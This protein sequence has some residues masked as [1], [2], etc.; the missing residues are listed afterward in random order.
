M[1]FDNMKKFM[2]RLTSW[3][4]PGN[5][6]SVCIDNKEVFKYQS[7][8]EDIENRVKMSSDK[9]FNV[10]SCSKLITVVAA[11]QLYEKGY[12]LLDDPL[13]EYIPEYKTMYIKDEKGNEKKACNNITL[14]HLFTMTSGIGYDIKSPSIQKAYEMTA[15][16]MQTLTV[17]K[18]IA[19]EPLSFEP[20]ANWLYGLNHDI[21]AAVVEVISGKRFSDYVKENIFIPIEMNDSY[22]HNEAI[23]DRV[24]Q[25][26]KYE[27]SDETD[28]VT[29]QSKNRSH[30]GHII[31]V[32][33]KVDFVF[34][35]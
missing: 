26:Y 15:G 31:N 29:L 11:L 17:A 1:D 25:L 30:V 28:L 13:Y 16:K 32:G 24:A 6:I 22:Y 23:I 14:R 5:C 20:G 27:N 9:L 4:I 33:K 10:F 8:Y 34:D 12:Y 18:Y 2:D 3:R 19:D 21:L 35:E 7:G